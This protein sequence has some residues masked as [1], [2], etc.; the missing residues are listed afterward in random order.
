MW[1]HQP[2]RR[3]FG[4]RIPILPVLVTS[5]ETLQDL[6]V[7]FEGLVYALPLWA[8]VVVAFVPAAVM[9]VLMHPLS[10]LL[11]ASKNTEKLRSSLSSLVGTAFVFLVS[12]STNT[13]WRDA[14][15]LS[16]NVAD[17]A[18]QERDLYLV[19]RQTAPEQAEKLLELVDQHL[20][21]VPFAPLIH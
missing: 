7:W 19:L 14:S 2:G 18:V 8:L 21:H 10:Y 11:D 15:T 13:L 1:T 12:L 20:T 5:S 17:L 16:G 9:A 6:A 4:N 3:Y